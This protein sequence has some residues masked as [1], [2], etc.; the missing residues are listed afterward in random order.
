MERDVLLQAKNITLKFGKNL[1]LKNLSIEVK[2]GEILGIA[3]VSGAGKTTLINV[4]T[5]VLK[6]QNGRVVYN[7]RIIN[8]Q[9]SKPIELSKNRKLLTK[10]IGYS[11]QSSSFFEELTVVENLDFFGELWNVPSD[12]RKKNMKTLL[13]LLALTDS[14]QQ[15]GIKLSGGMKKRLDIACALIHNPKLL[16]LDEPTADLDPILRGKIWKIVQGL[17]EQGTTFVIASHFL[18]E[19]ENVCSST[20]ILHKGKITAKIPIK[21]KLTEIIVATNSQSFKKELLKSELF[22]QDEI[23]STPNLIIVTRPINANEEKMIRKLAQNIGLE[24]KEI[25]SCSMALKTI[26]NEIAK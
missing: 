12:I 4:L 23:I 2:Q 20:C 7:S 21:K 8:P 5:G 3:G 14:K 6:P 24:I 18:E 25:R 26:F 10:L 1:V 13:E 9:E 16:F 17:N 22:S 11:T 19:I 15:L